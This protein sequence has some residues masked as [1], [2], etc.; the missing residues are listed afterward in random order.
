LGGIEGAIAGSA[1]GALTGALV[2]LGFSKNEAIRYES[3]IKAGKFL[4]TLKGDSDQIE[5]AKRLVVDSNAESVD[6][7]EPMV[8]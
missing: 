3:Q 7:A 2:S 4:V 5:K 6:V 1:V 8:A